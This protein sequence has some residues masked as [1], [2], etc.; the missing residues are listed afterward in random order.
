MKKLLSL[1]IAVLCILLIKFY[2]IGQDV[3]SVGTLIGSLLFL[4][5]IY[6]LVLFFSNSEDYFI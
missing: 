6:L 5:I 4:D 1:I 2:P 3:I